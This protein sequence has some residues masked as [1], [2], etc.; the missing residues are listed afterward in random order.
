MLLQYPVGV[1]V[2]LAEQPEQEMLAPD[3]PSA[4]LPRRGEGELQRPLGARGER[5]DLLP[6]FAAEL[7]EA[8]PHPVYVS[9]SA[10]QGLGRHV[11]A[12]HDAS[13]Q[14]VRPDS[15]RPGGAGRRLA[16]PHHGLL[17]LPGERVEHAA[18]PSLLLLY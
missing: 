1:P 10:L 18:L 15:R 16:G 8:R 5:V 7:L 4:H 17:R 12:G 2:A 11:V 6:R 14:V 13:E 3:L 9:A